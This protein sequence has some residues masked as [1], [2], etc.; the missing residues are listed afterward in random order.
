M[1]RRTLPAG[2]RMASAAPRT[3]TWCLYVVALDPRIRQRVV[4]CARDLDLSCTL[5]EGDGSPLP[6]HR[7]AIYCLGSRAAARS[8]DVPQ[9]A[10][11]VTAGA[12]IPDELLGV[13]TGKR[14]AAMRLLNLTPGTLLEALMRLTARVDLDGLLQHLAGHFSKV[15]HQFLAAF[16]LGPTRIATLEHIARA[17]ERR[18]PEARRIVAA[19]GCRQPEHLLAALRS[20]SYSWLSSQGFARSAIEEYLGIKDHPT[21]R[22]ACHRAGVPVPWR[23]AS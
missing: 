11:I 10:L 12:A 8:K 14:W 18:L 15:P 20:E 3:S 22:R 9:P 16:V 1:L 19:A 4:Q 17:V 13:V 2:K 6:K 7:G 5:L 23:N 21:F